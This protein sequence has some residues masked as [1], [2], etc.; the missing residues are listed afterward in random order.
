MKKVTLFEAKGFNDLG[1]KKFVIQDS[2]YCKILH[3][4][5]RAGQQLPIHS[6]DIEGQFSIAW[7][8]AGPGA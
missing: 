2:P 7:S 4:N 5:F 3:F 1:L 8:T 6:H